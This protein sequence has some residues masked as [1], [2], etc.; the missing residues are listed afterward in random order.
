[1]DFVHF[2]AYKKNIGE[3]YINKNTV[4]YITPSNRDNCTEVVFIA[5]HNTILKTITVV[6]SFHDVARKLEN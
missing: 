2:E 6:G 4:A 5:P 1:M 3:L